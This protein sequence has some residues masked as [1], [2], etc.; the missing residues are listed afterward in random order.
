MPAHQPS[1][2]ARHYRQGDLLRKLDEALDRLYPGH[3]TL[4]TDDLHAVDE[5]HT[6]GHA[7]TLEPAEHLDLRAGMRVLDAGI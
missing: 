6:G 5:F 2:A 7:T 4:T 3:T 1:A